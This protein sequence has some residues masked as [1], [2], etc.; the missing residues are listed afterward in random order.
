MAPPLEGDKEP[1]R[2]STCIWLALA[3]DNYQVKKATARCLETN[4]QRRRPPLAELSRAIQVDEG[5]FLCSAQPCQAVAEACLFASALRERRTLLP[6]E[7]SVL[8][9]KA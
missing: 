3:A 1:R 9:R 6:L 2:S 7:I 5:E 8:S 4:Q